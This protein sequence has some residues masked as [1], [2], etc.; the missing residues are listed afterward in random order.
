MRRHSLGYWA[1]QALGGVLSLGAAIAVVLAL[2][3]FLGV[4]P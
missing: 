4:V 3:T 2:W 1:R